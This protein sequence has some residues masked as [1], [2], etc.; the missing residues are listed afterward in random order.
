MAEKHSV[1]YNQLNEEDKEFVNFRLD[2]EIF[3]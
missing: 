3:S 2:E 1:T